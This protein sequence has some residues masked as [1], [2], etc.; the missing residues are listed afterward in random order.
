MKQEITA[1]E[2]AKTNRTDADW[3][4]AMGSTT[5]I[6]WKTGDAVEY[7]GFEGSVVRHYHN[8]MFEVRLPGG[9]ACVDGSNLKAA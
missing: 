6:A 2:F 9:V 5:L 1:Q 8:G 4:Q 3:V 7:S